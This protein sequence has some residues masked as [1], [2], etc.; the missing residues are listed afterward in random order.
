[1]SDLIRSYPRSSSFAI[2]TPDQERALHERCLQVLERTGVS[3][4]N[5]MLLKVM[6]DHGQQ[7]DFENQRIRFSPDFVEEKRALAPRR[8]TLHARNPERN[9]TVGG[10]HSIFIPAAG[11]P[12]V[13]DL[14]GTRRNSR[15]A[16]TFASKL[17]DTR[18]TLGPASSTRSPR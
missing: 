17:R 4:T 15:L 2:L 9:A 10:K 14:D 6:A 3:T 1:M 11:S 7:V 16:D 18:F 13:R 5:E 8:Y 12:Y